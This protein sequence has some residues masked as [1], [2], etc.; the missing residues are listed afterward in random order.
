MNARSINIEKADELLYV[1]SFNDVSCVC[2]TETWFKDVMSDESVGLSG[3][4]CERKDRSGH[5]GGGVA[6]YVAATVAYDRLHDI[7][8]DIHEV[9]WIRMR[10]HKLPGR[11]ASIVIACIYH[12][13]NSGNSSMMRI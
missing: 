1:T 2:V 3:Y 9:M 12:P 7:E 5:A 8:D 11:F 13:P 10:H 6:C 4:C